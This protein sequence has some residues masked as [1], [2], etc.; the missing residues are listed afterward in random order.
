MGEA[1]ALPEDERLG[2]FLQEDEGVENALEEGRLDEISAFH[3]LEEAI[4]VSS[5]GKG[6]KED[7]SPPEEKTLEKT[8][9]V[10]LKTFFCEK[11]YSQ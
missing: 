3:S 10:G 7:L 4:S 6:I 1:S 8:F 5:E 2:G 11:V 9:E